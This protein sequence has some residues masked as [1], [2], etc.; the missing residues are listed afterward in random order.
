MQTT[1][2]YLYEGQ[3]IDPQTET[4][5]DRL[6]ALHAAN[7][8]LT[9]D[10]CPAR[11]EMYLA[12][13]GTTVLIKRMPDTGHLHAPDCTSFE[14]PEGFSGRGPLAGT[15]I[16][17]VDEA[18]T[19]LR[20]GFPLS[21]G[22]LRAAPRP[23]GGTAIEVTPKPGKLGITALL[24]YLW[25]EAGLNRWVPAM[26]GK[27]NWRVVR[28]ALMGAAQNHLIKGTVPLGG[29]LFVPE[30]FNQ[31][32]K[33]AIVERR[34]ARLAPI[35]KPDNAEFGILIAEYKAHEPTRFG[36]RFTFKHL[37]DLPFFADEDQMRQFARVT[38]RHLGLID[39]IGNGH[40]I[41]VATFGSADAGYP[42]LKQMGVMA[43][44]QNWL[45][46]EDWHHAELASAMCRARRSFITSLRYNL[47]QD[48]PLCAMMATDT[49]QPVMM[50]IDSGTSEGAAHLD[51]TGLATWVW[52]T[53]HAMPALPQRTH[54]E[55]V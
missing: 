23:S 42:V 17:G 55:A 47:Q 34:K 51:L 46:V 25:E 24:H 10:C 19:G 36:A 27:R 4:G 39:V 37:P 16:V 40:L 22:A 1:A 28:G 9:C 45:P 5:Q 44:D 8:R 30:T 35:M 50:F 29:R 18:T 13:V 48:A 41:V 49:P 43:V 12:K 15:A 11:P 38:E 26:H 14:P 7:A 20:L 32:Y 54:P 3:T 52:D 33:D 31:T 21:K 6:L 53:N 2:R